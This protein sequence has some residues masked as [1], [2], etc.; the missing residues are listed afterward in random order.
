MLSEFGSTAIPE[1]SVFHKLLLA[2]GTNPPRLALVPVVICEQPALPP[3]PPLLP[4]P[5]PVPV[6]PDPL[7]V[8][9][10]ALL[11]D[12]NHTRFRST[13]PSHR[14]LRVGGTGFAI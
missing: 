13:I 3:V 9:E 1:M 6:L 5:V 12:A 11:H 4:P 8:L 2:N 14:I 10:L 7:P